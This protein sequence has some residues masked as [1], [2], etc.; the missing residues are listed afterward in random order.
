MKRIDKLN[1]VTLTVSAIVL[2]AGSIYLSK[3]NAGVACYQGT[4]DFVY[5]DGYNEDTGKSVDIYQN[6]IG[7]LE[8]YDNNTGKTAYC[9][10]I[11][12]VTYCD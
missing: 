5:C 2:V 1:M 6:S 10:T 4:G 12:G 9:Q 7:D 8:L 3:A 11:D